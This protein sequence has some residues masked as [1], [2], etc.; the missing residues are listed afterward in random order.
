MSLPI[1]AVGALLAALLE[2][3]V[4]PELTIGGVKPDLVLVLAVVVAMVVGFEDS[5]VWA[6]VGGLLIDALSGRPLGAT[7]L[8]LLVVTG[9][10]VLLARFT[11]RPRIITVGVAVFV[12][13]WLFLAL[14]TAIL[15]A[16]AGV[17]LTPVPL[18]TFIALAVLDTI[19]AILAVIVIRALLRRYGAT[20]RIDW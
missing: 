17:G 15:A 14:L 20:E 1:A 8:V 6:V 4:L 7:A 16:T 18:S 9:L 3:S 12:S 19:V 13:A 2:T 5:M 10:A 11:G